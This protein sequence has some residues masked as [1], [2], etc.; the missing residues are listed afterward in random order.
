MKSV[1]DNICRVRNSMNNAI[2]LSKDIEKV[3]HNSFF[4]KL[5]KLGTLAVVSIF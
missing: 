5:H 2:E 3:R 1:T 4:T